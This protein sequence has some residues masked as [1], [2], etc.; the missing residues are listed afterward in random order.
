MNN[1]QWIKMAIILQFDCGVLSL[2]LV[3]RMCV[4]VSC[5]YG[6]P[7]KHSTVGSLSVC[8]RVEDADE[9]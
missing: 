8:T 3:K 4:D 7:V 5:R 9:R 1:I 6:L 2:K